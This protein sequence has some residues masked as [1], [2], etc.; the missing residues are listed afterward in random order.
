VS[1]SERLGAAHRKVLKFANGRKFHRRTLPGSEPGVLVSDQS[2]HP[3]TFRIMVYG[4]GELV[5]KSLDRPDQIPNPRQGQVLWVDVTGLA[6]ADVIEAI[7]NRFNLHSLALEDVLH[8]HQRAKTEEYTET[9]FVVARM[10]YPNQIRHSEQVS[11]FL[12]KNFVITFQEDPGDCFN[13]L[14]ERIRQKGRIQ[15]RSADYLLY[16]LLDAI[17]DAYFPQL[18][19]IGAELDEIDVQITANHGRY[20]LGRLHEIRRELIALRKLLW[21]HRD[22]LNALVRQESELITNET[23][24]YLRDCLDHV[25][26]LMDVSENDRDSCIG[27]QDLYLTELGQRTNDIMRVLTLFSSLFL[28]MTFIAG[29]YGMNFNT[30]S[31][32]YNL[33]ELNWYYGYPFSLA[34][35]GLTGILLMALFWFRGWFHR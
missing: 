21:Q 29:V 5:E 14:R 12:G 28:P 1:L 30:Q 19:R 33:P 15:T 20:H 4:E 9:L 25:V 26:Q 18:E 2:K 35:M 23:Q 7:G 8:I 32:P 31:S 10:L 6:N 27:L 11:L 22:A 13:S 17:I 16:G 34:L 24:I 3:T